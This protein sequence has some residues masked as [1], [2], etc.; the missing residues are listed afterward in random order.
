MMPQDHPVHDLLRRYRKMQESGVVRSPQ[1]GDPEYVPGL[2]P[3]AQVPGN[4]PI[5]KPG[6]TEYAPGGKTFGPGASVD[7]ARTGLEGS[8]LGMD[9]AQK[10]A[11]REHLAGLAKLP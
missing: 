2:P 6:K 3:P 11:Y 8:Q 4:T 5:S 9:E 1:P 10:Q 7:Q